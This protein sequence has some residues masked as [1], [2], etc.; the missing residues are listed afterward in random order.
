MCNK[1]R[2]CFSVGSVL[3]SQNTQLF[4]FPFRIKVPFFVAWWRRTDRERNKGP[5]CRTPIKDQMKPKSKW[6]LS[7]FS[8]MFR[9][10][11]VCG[12]ILKTAY[13]NTEA[14]HPSMKIRIFSPT[15]FLFCH[16]LWRPG[17]AGEDWLH[18]RCDN[19]PEEVWWSSTGVC[20]L[21]GPANHRYR[22]TKNKS[23][24]C[25]TAVTQILYGVQRM[26]VL[27][28]VVTIVTLTV[29]R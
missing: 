21:R 18:A 4:F 17:F 16:V 26:K 6:E 9:S 20:P 27:S 8:D 7:P 14:T 3:S 19:R 1:L 15:Y 11:A 5:K 29:Y 28:S 12:W 23:S 22:G 13:L 25:S 2:C 10:R 24:L